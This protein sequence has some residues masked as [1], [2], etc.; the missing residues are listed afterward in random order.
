M[1][2]CFRVDTERSKDLTELGQYLFC[3]PRIVF[4]HFNEDSFSFSKKLPKWAVMCGCSQREQSWGA[5]NRGSTFLSF[6]ENT[7]AC[8]GSVLSSAAWKQVWWGTSSLQMLGKVFLLTSWQSQPTTLATGA[9][10][11][12]PST[13]AYSPHPHPCF[14]LLSSTPLSEPQIKHLF[15]DLPD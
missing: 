13:L 9:T 1:L 15:L 7:T 6:P 12:A 4:S 5:H 11:H 8:P 3:Q 14:S 10:I 2:G